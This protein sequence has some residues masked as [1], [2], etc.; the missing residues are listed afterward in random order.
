MENFPPKIELYIE[1]ELDIELDINN[2]NNNNNKESQQSI[3]EI[4]ENEFGRLLSPIEI[5]I[6]SKWDYPLEILKMAVAEATSTNNLAIK[7]IDSILYNW[8]KKNLRSAAEVNKYLTDYRERKSNR[9]ANNLPDTAKTGANY[10][11]RLD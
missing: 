8:N 7:Y 4:I 2:S 3:Y 11:P 10:Y 9:K 1:Q 6:I 5:E